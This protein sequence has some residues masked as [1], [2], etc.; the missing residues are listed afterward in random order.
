MPTPS[1]L[2]TSIDAQ[3]TDKTNPYSIDNV[4]VGSRMKD[5]IDLTLP[6]QFET[7]ASRIS[8]LTNPNRQPFESADDKEDGNKYYLNKDANAWIK[9]TT[10]NAPKIEIIIFAGQSVL[11]IAWNAGRK[12]IFGNAASFTIE[13][14][15]AD[16]KYRVKHGLEIYPDDIVNTT[17]Y[18]IDLGGG[19]QSGRL[20][21]K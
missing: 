8:Y 16:G 20:T 17:T 10:D 7:T 18:T 21:I 1:Q 2:K 3:I 6:L 14:L 12:A 9:F 11:N 13:T 4:D 5:I 15:D 19:A